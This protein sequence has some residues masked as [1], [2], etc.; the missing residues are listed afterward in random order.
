MSESEADPVLFYEREFYCLSCFSAFAITLWG[1][2]WPTPE[3]AYQSAKFIDWYNK[4]IILNARSP[5][6]AK[7]LAQSMKEH[8]RG[9]LGSAMKLEFMEIVSR[10]MVEQH[11]YIHTMLLKTG[12]REIIEDSPTD[13]FWGT[14]PDGK[15]YNHRGKIWMKIRTELQERQHFQ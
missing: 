2:T 3:H 4:N 9:D 1:R 12:N 14:G 8:Q 11:E 15:G 13:S 6:E 10:A 5:V 7:E